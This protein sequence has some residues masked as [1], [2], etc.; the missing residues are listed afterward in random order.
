MILRCCIFALFSL[1]LPLQAHAQALV[2][3]GE[4]PTFSRLV[5]YLPNSISWDLSETGNGYALSVPEWNSGFDVSSVFEMIPRSRIASVS[6]KD[7]SLEIEIA[8]QC[9]VSAEALDRGGVII[10]VADGQPEPQTSV[11]T[12]DRRQQ[13]SLPRLE[14]AIDLPNPALVNA[15]EPQQSLPD[16]DAFR[17]TL[18]GNLGRSASLS[19]IDLDVEK[20]SPATGPNAGSPTVS[21][22]VDIYELSAEDRLRVT[23]ALDAALADSR[24]KGEAA[25][26]SSCPRKSQFE[27]SQWAGDDTFPNQLAQ[28]RQTLMGEFDT[29]DPKAAHALTRLYLYFGLGTEARNTLI[30]FDLLGGDQKYLVAISD[31]LEPMM[32][33]PEMSLKPF[34][35]CDAAIAIWAVLE[36]GQAASLSNAD[37]KG[38]VAEFAN[39]PIHLRKDLGARLIEAMEDGGH[40]ASA[41]VVKNAVKRSLGVKK[42]ELAFVD[43]AVKPDQP[44]PSNQ[45]RSLI[46]QDGEQAPDALDLY[47][48]QLMSESQPLDPAMLELAGAYATELAGLEISD[49]LQN[50]YLLGLGY[51]GQLKAA[52]AQFRRMAVQDNLLA[53]ASTDTLLARFLAQGTH[54]DIAMISMALLQTDRVR[55]LSESNV[56]ALISKVLTI[57]LPDLAQTLMERAEM[58]K[59][60][61]LLAA[62][63]E[64]AKGDDSEAEQILRQMSDQ[65]SRKALAE[66]LLNS[67]R[68]EEAWSSLAGRVPTDTE[69]QMAWGASEWA[70]VGEDS[71]RRDV[72]KLIAGVPS[73]SIEEAPLSAAGEL[74]NTSQ[75]SRQ[76]VATLLDQ[77][78]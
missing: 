19:L 70:A 66:L 69:N 8:C 20:Q 13:F 1:G 27:I 74:R 9:D 75:A 76:A 63:I 35:K 4:H 10:D 61:S 68:A 29:L 47:L 3:S 45:L 34:L 32:D 60:Q 77:L 40:V 39:W 52:S 64:A 71:I 44:Y 12:A 11:E 67:G 54:E 49:R 57:G 62:E 18:L 65:E 30:Q 16:L 31:V 56:N 38:I 48:R 5:V 59:G 17:S 37:I 15:I 24:L 43:A 33:R 25:P 22:P 55:D 36:T 46:S 23:S 50:T 21:E 78:P 2:K 58:L 7:A 41:S 14:R 42:S 26:V 51:S 53:P 6:A 28:L 72:A 73:T